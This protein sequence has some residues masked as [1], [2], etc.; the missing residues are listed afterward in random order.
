MPENLT[1]II[2][3]IIYT[4]IGIVALWGAFCVVMV[5]LRVGAKRF[6][7]EEQQ[8]LFPVSYTHLTLPTR[9]FV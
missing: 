9:I 3:Y 7:S 4:V 1:N 6:R 8:Q 2:G 5:W